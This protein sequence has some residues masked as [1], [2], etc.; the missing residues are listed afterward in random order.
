MATF[1]LVSFIGVST[2]EQVLRAAEQKVSS[3]QNEVSEQEIYQMS[4]D[5]Y[6]NYLNGD[7]E[8]EFEDKLLN[9]EKKVYA[10][11]K[12]RASESFQV[13]NPYAPFSGYDVYSVDDDFV[14]C[15]EPGTGTLSVA[16]SVSESGSTFNKFSD[17]SK[18]YVSKVISSA[19][20]HYNNS[21]NMNYIF[22][23]QLLIWEYL[24]ENETSNMPDISWGDKETFLKSFDVHKSKEYIKQINEIEKDINEW[25]TLP[26]FATNSKSKAYEVTLPYDTSS[27]TFNIT[28][29]DDN[30]VWDSKYATYGTY[31]QYELSNPKGSDNVKI[32][33]SAENLN[34]SSPIKFTWTP[35]D[36]GEKNFYDA[37]QDLVHV[38]AEPV[39]AYMKIKTEKRKQGGFKL[40]KIDGETNQKLAGAEFTLYDESGT[41]V[42]TY[43]TDEEGLINS[44]KTLDRGNYM[45]KETKAPAG[46]MLSDK[47]YKFTIKPDK[48]TEV[49]SEPIKNDIIRGGFELSKLGEVY[50]L[51]N[52]YLSGVEFTVTSS[53]YPDF[54]K[55]YVSD[56][57]GQIT[58]S[59]KELKYGK[60]TITET[61][62]PSDYVSNYSEEFEITSNGDIVKLNKGE[63][64]INELYLNKVHV[65]KNAK[66]LVNGDND[67]KPLAGSTFGIY[68]EVGE[69]NGQLDR[70]DMIVDIQTTDENGEFTS[71]GLPQGNYIIK[72]ISAPTGYNLNQNSY[73]FSIVNDGT[74]ENGS[75]IELGEIE[76]RVITGTA[77][78]TKVGVGSCVEAK[79]EKCQT[80]LTDVSFA[81]YADRNNNNV[82]DK[83]EDKPIEVIKTDENGIA[84]TSSLKYGHY[85]VKEINTLENYILNSVV[86]DFSITEQDQV[87]KVNKGEPIENI[88]KLGQLEIEKS[89][90]KIGNLNDDEVLLKGAEYTIY[91][92]EENVVEVITTNENGYAISSML[93]FGSYVVRET[94]APKGYIVDDNKYEFIIDEDS[95]QIPIKL[96]LYDEVI[97]NTV[98]ISKVDAA[99]GEE[100]PGATL[101]IIDDSNEIID[102]WVST[103]EAHKSIVEYG[104]YQ[105]CETIAPLGYKKNTKCTKFSVTEDGVK[106]TFTI[107]NK[108]LPE[109]IETGTSRY[110][111]L[112]LTSLVASLTCA[113]LLSRLLRKSM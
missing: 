5:E 16:N 45:I 82:L 30:G 73:P 7:D 107:E 110:N 91:D 15:V 46:Y 27:D 44:G 67:M 37:G 71:S 84:T 85:F 28:L 57:N 3:N 53:T 74:L 100:L 20:E 88:E 105:I 102:E 49:S 17:Q 111:Y 6:T 26:S 89:G 21:S 65:T 63:P 101:Q 56:E 90:N 31:G 55:V 36:S 52:E 12:Y 59:N 40:N 61:D 43:T 92:E 60:Y 54:K 58:T 113:M 11:S 109:V 19:I 103:S 14:F 29:K 106:Q 51:E 42:K 2:I 32:T 22:A 48:I 35:V 87:V 98:I 23:G 39:S 13:I 64:I 9:E 99:N 70:Q 97:K 18:S 95:Y 112:L 66:S 25:D 80:P 93:P 24:G 94:S 50:N 34:F 79:I 62:A 108:L 68:E 72:E 4:L 33:T 83:N 76:N 96:Q 10:V 41:I 77:A 8:K 69:V 75:T 78:L 81:I 1:L 47:E 38:G 104:D 86:Y